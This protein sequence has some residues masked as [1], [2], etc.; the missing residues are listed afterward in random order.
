MEEAVGLADRVILMKTGAIK[1]AF[2]ID[3]PHPRH[4]QGAA[5]MH[6][7]NQVRHAFFNE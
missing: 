6:E 7:L 5:F 4:E 3:L 1:K 2:A